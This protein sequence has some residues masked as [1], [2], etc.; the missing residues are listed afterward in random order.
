MTG[1]RWWAAVAVLLTVLSVAVVASQ[2]VQ[3]GPLG[4]YD[5]WT[6]LD[7]VD[8]A[9][10]GGVAQRGELVD[11]YALHISSCRGS[12]TEPSVGSPCGG[13]LDPTVYP[14]RGV[15]SA[16]IHPPTYFVLTA[17]GASL[18][19][20]T[21]PVDELVDAARATGAVWA[22]AGLLLVVLLAR[23]LGARPGWAVLAALACL[24][25]PLVRTSSTHVTPD[26]TALVV[27]AGVALATVA[28]LRGGRWWWL[29]AASAAAPAFKAPFELVVACCILV[30]VLSPGSPARRLVGAACLA[31]PAAAVT[32][33]WL[34]VRRGLALGEAPV[35]A[36]VLAEPTVAGVLADLDVAVGLPVDSCAGASCVVG[37]VVGVWWVLALLAAVAAAAAGS[38]DAAATAR[39]AVAVAVAALVAGPMSQAALYLATGTVF[40]TPARYA[41][42]LVPVLSAVAAAACSQTVRQPRGTEAPGPATLTA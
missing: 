2:V 40:T 9:D 3:R 17:A 1:R 14:Q 11:P 37:A 19:Q 5:E 29:A 41:V 42:V 8:K 6:F 7:A 23:R 26:A 31:V 13:P 35:Q 16:D 4:L 20:V 10:R 21:T 24:A 18:V 27:G 28:W 36:V 33:G 32:V 34:V 25:V 12:S 15:T 38:R 39:W 22:A 30:V